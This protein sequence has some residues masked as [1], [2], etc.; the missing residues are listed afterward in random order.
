M[1]DHIGAF[2]VTAGLGAD[3]LAKRFENEV[4]IEAID[5]SPVRAVRLRDAWL[6]GALEE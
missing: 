1:P 6:G 3:E 4:R 5:G 2:A